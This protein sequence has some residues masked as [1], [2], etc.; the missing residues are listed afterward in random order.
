MTTWVLEEVE[1]AS[2][3]AWASIRE[4]SRCRRSSYS[5]WLS[6]GVTS[7]EEHRSDMLCFSVEQQLH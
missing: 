5:V 1:G 6:P 3:S 4:A 7:P 2:L